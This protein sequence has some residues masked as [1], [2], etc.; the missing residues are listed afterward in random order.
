[1]ITGITLQNLRN[2]EF[3]QFIKDVLG[4]VSLNNPATLLVT[5]E[6]NALVTSADAVSGLFKNELSNPITAEIEL[7]DERRD[8]AI[9]GL[10][11]A[12]LAFTYHFDATLN[13]QATLLANNL[14][15]YGT[16]IAKDNYQSE[17][18]TLNSIISD[19]TNKPEL[20][21]AVTALGLTA[22]KA[23]LE[24]ANT[25]FNAKYLARTQDLGAASPDTMKAKRLEAATAY[26]SLRDNINA[27]FIIKKG[28]EPFA[29]ASNELNALVSQ[30]NALLAGRVSTATVTIE[31]PPVTT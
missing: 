22:W 10:Y 2:S 12:T 9:N 31:T 19:W 23:E 11:Y 13:K 18:A 27:H 25:A 15:L 28:A 20:A 1:M 30:Y 16:G 26:Y 17:T 29:K 8:A 21:A 4:I 24:A 5:D 3:L 7:L 6:Y 14:A